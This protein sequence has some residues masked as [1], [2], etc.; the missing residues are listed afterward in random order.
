MPVSACRG[1]L[2]T[3]GTHFILVGMICV[4]YFVDL[5]A[6][7]PRLWT[8]S[9]AIALALAAC[10]AMQGV[11]VIAQ[12]SA[13]RGSGIDVTSCST[14]GFEDGSCQAPREVGSSPRGASSKGL[15][16]GL[17]VGRVSSLFSGK[18]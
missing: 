5:C 18:T 1:A 7:M 15:L 10:L 2:L 9:A 6:Q 3:R 17:F 16:G 8:V 14:A 11:G 4:F 13:T 12:T